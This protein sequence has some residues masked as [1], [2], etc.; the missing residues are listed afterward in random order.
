MA[1]R[2]KAFTLVEL[3]LIVVF[4]GILAAIAIP[5]LSF[6]TLSKQKADIIARKIVTDLRRTRRLAI[7]NAAAN[8]NGFALNMTGSSPYTGYE[9][10]NLNTAVTVD[11]HTIAPDVGC[12]GGDEFR[13]GPLG[14]LL[15]GSAHS[16]AVSAN[17]KIFTI[18]II[19]ATGTV[20]CS[21]N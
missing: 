19:S 20:K 9:I 1:G 14:N 5:R 12:T 10:E 21:E 7:S 13:F 3:L 17:G 4:L 11:S 2:P 15:S 6:S 8:P 16:L 18:S